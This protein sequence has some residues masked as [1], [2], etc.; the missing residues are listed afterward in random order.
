MFFSYLPGAVDTAGRAAFMIPIEPALI[1][2]DDMLVVTRFFGDPALGPTQIVRERDN[3]NASHGVD[4]A[5]ALIPWVYGTK[6][7]VATRTL[8][9]TQT[10]T[11]EIDAMVADLGYSRTEGSSDHLFSWR[12]IAPTS[13]GT[14]VLPDLPPELG[15]IEPK[16]GDAVVGHPALYLIRHG[17]ETYAQLRQHLDRD[18]A[19][20][21]TNAN[22]PLSSK[23]TVSHFVCGRGCSIPTP[24]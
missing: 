11:G 8:R 16:A 23:L 12:V 6:L 24:P 17:D 13:N 14:L 20:F 5:S 1:A 19:I 9:W 2:G 10:G 15:D 7:D 18:A 21:N 3:V 22:T 4:V